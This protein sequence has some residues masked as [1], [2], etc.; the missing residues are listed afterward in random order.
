VAS[1]IGQRPMFPSVIEEPIFYRRY[2]EKWVREAA[3]EQKAINKFIHD[4]T[5]PQE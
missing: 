4:A 3:L 5:H 2:F 1:I